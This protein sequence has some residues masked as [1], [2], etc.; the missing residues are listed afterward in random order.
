SSSHVGGPPRKPDEL[1][2]VAKSRRFNDSGR[3]RA[4]SR[5]ITSA[6]SQGGRRSA[7]ANHS[8]CEALHFLELRAELQQHEVNTSGFELRQT[9]G[10]LFRRANQPGPQAAIRN[11]IIFQRNA[12]LQLRSGKPLLVVRVARGGLLNIRHSPQLVLRLAFRFANNGISSNAKLEWRQ[13]VSRPAF[14]EIRDF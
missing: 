14:S 1:P 6:S 3:R 2:E 7:R 11:R 4:C 13:I 5:E 10:H 8:S 9:L 12:L